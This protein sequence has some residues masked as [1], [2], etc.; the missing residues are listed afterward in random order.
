MLEKKTASGAG[1]AGPQTDAG[2]PGIDPLWL[3]FI[4]ALSLSLNIPHSAAPFQPSELNYLT[5][6]WSEKTPFADPLRWVLSKV[7]DELWF[8]SLS[9]AVV[10]LPWLIAA[11]LGAVLTV[12]LTSSSF[13]VHAGYAAGIAIA[14]AGNE[15]LSGVQL[16]S[17]P[18][19]L[20][21]SL[22]A[23]ASVHTRSS[24]WIVTRTVFAAL[25]LLPVVR[26]TPAGWAPW[27]AVG[28]CLAEQLRGRERGKK[29]LV[30]V[31]FLSATATFA[32]VQGA[33]QKS[34]WHPWS[35]PVLVTL[36]GQWP[37]WLAPAAWSLVILGGW[38]ATRGQRGRWICGW[39][40]ATV[41]LAALAHYERWIVS[42]GLLAVIL[43]PFL[44][45]LGLGA[46]IL[47]DRLGGYLSRPHLGLAVGAVI[48]GAVVAIPSRV[49]HVDGFRNW[50]TVA[51]LVAD[52]AGGRDVFATALCRGAVAFYAPELVNQL[53]VE[54]DL[55]RALVVF[56]GA[57]SGWLVTPAEARLNPAWA[58]VEEWVRNFG[59]IDL[60]PQSGIHV[61]YYRRA[62]RQLA[63]RWA[64]DF[65]LPSGTLRRGRL[66]AEMLEAAGPVPALLWK[67]DQLVLDPDTIVERNEGLVE[68]VDKLIA[69]D[70]FD[71][72]L[73]LTERLLAF[74][75]SW[76][77]ALR[78]RERLRSLTAVGK[79][80]F[81]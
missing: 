28:T 16:N 59:V 26:L 48:A 23:V 64:A 69:F 57:E 66:L 46:G 2:Q 70:Q 35:A 5:I 14:G 33:A 9:E 12:R 34:F 21:L 40:V 71:R 6:P 63:L 52:N 68:V 75:P 51:R 58:R 47:G 42:D 11:A 19:A 76:E 20:L 78:A 80:L 81:D 44:L 67:V 55:G 38:K 65:T 32:V 39:L 24:R 43:F 62:G 25:L 27:L 18:W 1:R 72:A 41:V 3:L 7:G 31:L 60:S 73:S 15:A 79:G 22:A 50:R 45:F 61:F 53:P 30:L 4:A 29:L 56:P 10:R 17:G 8:W 54:A 36:K 37:M 77:R 49:A 13:G 74:D